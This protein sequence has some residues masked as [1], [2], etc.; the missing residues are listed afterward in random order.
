MRHSAKLYHATLTAL[1][2]M[3]ASAGVAVA[4]LSED[5]K[6]NEELNALRAKLI[7][8]WNPPAAVSN[9]PELYVGTVAVMIVGLIGVGLSFLD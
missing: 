4:N 5:A 2:M 1:L 6:L 9:Q 3:A 7:S 8:L